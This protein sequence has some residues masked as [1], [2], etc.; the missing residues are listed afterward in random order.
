M[1]DLPLSVPRLLILAVMF[2]DRVNERLDLLRVNEPDGRSGD[3]VPVGR[4]DLEL[5][6]DKERDR[7]GR[8]GHCVLKNQVRQEQVLGPVKRP[9]KAND[10]R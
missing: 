6:A 7:I 1:L 3:D 2:P 4:L 8:L 9:R 10:S 5:V